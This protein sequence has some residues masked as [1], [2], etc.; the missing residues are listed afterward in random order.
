MGFRSKGWIFLNMSQT[1]VLSI[2]YISAIGFGLAWG[3]I[4]INALDD[5]NDG[6]PDDIDSGFKLMFAGGFITTLFW[7]LSHFRLSIRCKIISIK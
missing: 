7:V 5:D 2:M 3:G 4:Y 6:N 1:A